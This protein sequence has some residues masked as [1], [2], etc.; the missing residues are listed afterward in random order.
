MGTG[1]LVVDSGLVAT[2]A[3]VLQDA[4]RVT[5]HIGPE[6]ISAGVVAVDEETDTA[7]LR[8]PA[9]AVAGRRPLPLGS[10]RDVPVSS[11]LWAAGYHHWQPGEDPHIVQVRVSR[12]MRSKKV[13]DVAGPIEH[14]ASGGPLIDP[15]QG[16]AVGLVR[17]G[18]GST[19]KV[20]VRIE[21][22]RSLLERSGRDREG[23]GEPE[24]AGAEEADS[25]W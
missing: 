17:G 12:N 21:Q 9:Q 14:G 10:S 8:V 25:S 4:T 22:V 2:A 13:F 11:E 6:Q 15:S 18:M 5:A 19:V 3:H 7:L 20:M 24:P 16:A 23:T 1:F